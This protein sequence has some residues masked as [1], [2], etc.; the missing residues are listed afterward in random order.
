MLQRLTGCL[1]DAKFELSDLDP[2]NSART[3]I[4]TAESKTSTVIV[5]E[6]RTLCRAC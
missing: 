6:S 1:E 3:E 5:Q 2:K 4:R